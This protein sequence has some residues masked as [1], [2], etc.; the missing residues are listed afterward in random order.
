VVKVPVR[1][2]IRPIVL[3]WDTQHTQIHYKYHIDYMDLPKSA[4]LGFYWAR[5]PN[6]ADRTSDQPIIEKPMQ[7]SK[8]DSPDSYL[9]YALL[10]QPP[11][12]A[13]HIL[14]FVDN[15]NQIDETPHEDNNIKPLSLDQL[16]LIA[17]SLNVDLDNADAIATYKITGNS[18]P[19]GTQFGLYWARGPNAELTSSSQCCLSAPNRF[20]TQM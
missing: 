20:Q 8:G 5:G 12:G 3:Q 14:L 17:V 10:G 19:A 6:W 1:P 18:A 7:Q 2:D 15:Q 9:P 4:T 11:T 13:S 16:D